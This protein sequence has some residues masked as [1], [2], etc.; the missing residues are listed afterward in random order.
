MA[1]INPP[2]QFFEKIWRG[3]VKIPIICTY[4][5]LILLSHPPHQ[6]NSDWKKL[7]IVV[8]EKTLYSKNVTIEITRTKNIEKDVH[9]YI[10]KPHYTLPRFIIRHHFQKI[11]PKNNIVNK[12]TTMTRCGVCDTLTNTSIILQN[13]LGGLTTFVFTMLIT[14]ILYYFDITP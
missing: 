11:S 8:K 14:T 12:G 3:N 1:N 6:L 4:K 7:N 10:F 9:A 13:M 5:P 2:G